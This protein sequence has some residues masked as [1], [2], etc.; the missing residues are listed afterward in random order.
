MRILQVGIFDPEKKDFTLIDH[1]KSDFD[2]FKHILGM[3]SSSENEKQLPKQDKSK[4][5]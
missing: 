5:N 3:D 4:V 1:F 2:N